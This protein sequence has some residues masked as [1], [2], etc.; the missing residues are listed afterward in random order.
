MANQ[1]RF[2]ND[3]LWKEVEPLLRKPKAGRGGYPVDNRETL[4]GIL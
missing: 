3:E 2:I 1:T 4:E